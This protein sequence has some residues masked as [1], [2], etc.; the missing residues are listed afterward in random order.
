MRK[1]DAA[2]ESFGEETVKK[3]RRNIKEPQKC[4][5][6]IFMNDQEK[7]KE[8]DKQNSLI[9]EL[10][11]WMKAAAVGIVLA[12]LLNR[13]VIV[14]AAVPTGSM[15]NTILPGDRLL[16]LRFTYLFSE[17]QRG[18]IVVFRYPIDAAR[19]IKKDFVKRIIGLPGETVEIRDAH[20]YINGCETPLDE[21][22][23]KEE[24][25]IRNDGYVFHVPEDHYLMMGDNRNTSSDARL[26][27]QDALEAGVAEN[28]EEAE[29]FCYVDEDLFLGKVDVRYWPLNRIS[30]LY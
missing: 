9:K 23:L 22:Y 15:E 5:K 14:N 25:V 19:G 1:D 17:P 16:G 2:S 4:R 8:N 29:R 26:W 7:K 28:W 6:G 13:Y 18:D 21:P 30:S 10:L 20:I 27:A 11:G 24:W 3:Y 12:L